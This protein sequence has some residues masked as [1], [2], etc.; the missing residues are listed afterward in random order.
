MKCERGQ[1]SKDR[2]LI[3]YGPRG[4]GKI[5]TVTKAVYYA[6]EHEDVIETVS[7]G[8]YKIDLSQAHTMKDVYKAIKYRLSLTIID[9]DGKNI[10]HSESLKKE[11]CILIFESIQEEKGLQR[12]LLP[13][14]K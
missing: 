14:L 13:F 4:V 9:L 1:G 3:V 8:A 12:E 7:D 2:L 5:D 6:K 10:I 11:K